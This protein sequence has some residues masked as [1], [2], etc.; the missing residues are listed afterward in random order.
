MEDEDDDIDRLLRRHPH[1]AP[2]TRGC[3][4]RQRRH[5][6]IAPT[7]V[8]GDRQGVPLVPGALGQRFGDDTAD[9]TGRT[10]VAGPVEATAA[11]NI[12]VQ[13]IAMKEVKDLEG[14]RSIVRK[15]FEVV[16]YK[17][18]TEARW[19]QALAKFNG[20]KKS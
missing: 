1:L 13:A 15:S 12:L 10:V 19:I 7:G 4:V 3:G 20:L 5:S 17:P 6:V 14:V 8:S 18:R 11:G 16:T 9:A 2:L